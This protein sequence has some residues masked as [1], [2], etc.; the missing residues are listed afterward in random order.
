MIDAGFKATKD[1]HYF[2]FCV[3][4]SPARKTYFRELDQWC[5]ETLHHPLQRPDPTTELN[6]LPLA[7]RRRLLAWIGK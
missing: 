5:E 4:D 6:K 7:E 1:G 3:A 2:Y